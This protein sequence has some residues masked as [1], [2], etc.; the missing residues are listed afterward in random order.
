ML[1]YEKLDIVYDLNEE[2]LKLAYGDSTIFIHASSAEAG[3]PNLTLLEAMSMGLP[4]AG[5]YGG[6]IELKGL[7]KAERNTQSVMSAIKEIISKYDMY[8]AGARKTAEMFDYSVIAKRLEL[9][10][11]GFIHIEDSPAREDMKEN[12]LNFYQDIKPMHRNSRQPQISISINFI[13]GPCAE[14]SGYGLPDKKYRVEFIDTKN[15]FTIYETTI[16]L[17]N[18]AKASRQYFSDW[19]IKIYDGDALVDR[20]RFDAKNKRVNVDQCQA[21]QSVTFAVRGI[22]FERKDIR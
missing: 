15:N 21:D 11:N 3:H 16:P 10:Y 8:S 4:I 7:I 18:W 19:L 2:D 22:G 12:L 17:N 14:L 6:S 5:T 20:H 9:V 13:N 1:S